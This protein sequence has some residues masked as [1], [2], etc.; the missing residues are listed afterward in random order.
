MQYLDAHTPPVAHSFVQGIYALLLGLILGLAYA[1]PTQAQSASGE[2]ADAPP[3]MVYVP[4][5]TTD[6]GSARGRPA[7]RPV[8]SATVDAFWMDIHP[9][10]VAQ[11]R[12]FVEDTGYTT[13]AERFGDAGIFDRT[14][15][16]W[17]LVKGAQ[18]RTPLGPSEPPAPDDHPVTQVS[19]N[20][21]SAFCTWADKR[22]PTE[23]EWE[24]AARGAQNARQPYAWG[25]ALTEQGTP[26]ANTWEGTFPVENTGA[27]GYQHTSPVGAF[28]TTPLGLTDMGGNV[29][30]W[31]ASPFQP[32]PLREA[33]MATKGPA[34]VQR[35]GSFMCH[36]SYC[37]GY[38]VSARSQSSPETSLFH[39]GFRCVKEA[40][41]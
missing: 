28:G 10:T 12:R 2:D 31:T 33:S 25:A 1:L 14:Q 6:I 35:G 40:S 16:Q 29:W 39:V 23:V 17:R 5:G 11:F 32:Y 19:W 27:D 20:D 7:E 37:H 41:E 36:A 13:E 26:R 21:A 9:V 38:R 34:M 22:L 15:R 4:S 18:W 30:E 8:F 24:H 3:G